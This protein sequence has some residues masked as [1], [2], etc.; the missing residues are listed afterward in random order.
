[1]SFL[2]R[3][4]QLGS[5]NEMNLTSRYDDDN[6]LQDAREALPSTQAL[7]ILKNPIII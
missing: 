3:S 1:M 7:K 6:A 2:N 4:S 5:L